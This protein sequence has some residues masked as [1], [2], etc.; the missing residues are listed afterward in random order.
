MRIKRRA[1]IDWW[2]QTEEER[3]TVGLE[4]GV[5]TQQHLF[6]TIWELNYLLAKGQR[7]LSSSAT[8]A[9]DLLYLDAPSR[10]SSSSTSSFANHNPPT[11]TITIRFRAQKY[12]WEKRGSEWAVEIQK[13][14]RQSP[15]SSWSASLRKRRAKISMAYGAFCTTGSVVLFNLFDLSFSSIRV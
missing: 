15:S 7:F 13:W 1:S 4:S 14:S 12:I 5:H 8:A 3:Q 11:T 10:S 6:K 2:K 9:A